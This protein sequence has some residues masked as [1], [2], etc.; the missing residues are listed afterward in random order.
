MSDAV[1]NPADFDPLPKILN[2]TSPGGNPGLTPPI[3]GTHGNPLLSPWKENGTDNGSSPKMS[4]RDAMLKSAKEDRILQGGHE[5]DTSPSSPLHQH[6]LFQNGVCQWPGCDANF[7]DLVLF[8]KHVAQEH[9][10]DDK[11]TA[12]AR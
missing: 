6:P 2:N 5:R 1:P 3:P 7:S 9:V 11:S 8:L 10:L 12:Q 4:A